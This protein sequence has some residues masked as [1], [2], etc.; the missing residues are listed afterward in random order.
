MTAEETDRPAT[1]RPLA[2][3][4]LR[5]L[6]ALLLAL[7]FAGVKL[8]GNRGVNV[9]E[10]LFYRQIGS[11]VCA[12][13]LVLAGPGLASLRTKRVGAHIGRMALG[14]SSMAMNFLAILL[15]PLADA[16]A[17][18]F[19]VPIFATI[20]AALVLG[21][22]TGRWRWAAVVAGFVGVLLIIHPGEGGVPLSGAAVAL[23]GAGMTAA[24]TIVIRRLGATER[25]STTVFW[26]AASSL[27]PLGLLMLRFGQAHDGTTFAIL[28]GMALAGGL[29]Q[30]TLTASLR[31]AP[32]ALVM[33]MD[34][35]SLLWATLLGVWLFAEL[36]TSS[37]WIG[38]PVIIASG[39]VIVW[40]EHHLARRA[41]LSAQA[42]T[43]A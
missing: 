43:S 28:A 4:L 22:A 25:A 1:Q 3:I 7:M 13:G 17:I 31:L 32:V 27:V 33:P 10:S 8:A 12:T 35:S 15:L 16:T 26:F 24:V 23:V 37:V 38:A 20:L 9:V 2:G 29:A 41:A 21:E 30:L 34:Y 11:V 18:G 42:A 39:L 40:R 6:T 5:L 36:P 19:T 14:L